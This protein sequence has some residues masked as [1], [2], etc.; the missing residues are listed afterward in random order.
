MPRNCPDWNSRLLLIDINQPNDLVGDCF[1]HDC[2]L[3][4]GE[5][6]S[7]SKLTVH[8]AVVLLR[9]LPMFNL[10]GDSK[11][12]HEF[13]NTFVVHYLGHPRMHAG[14]DVEAQMDAC[15]LKLLVVCKGSLSDI[16]PCP[17][18]SVLVD[19]EHVDIKGLQVLHLVSENCA[20]DGHPIDADAPV[21]RPDLDVSDKIESRIREQEAL[22]V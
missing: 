7:T 1:S 6:A 18:D 21:Q 12:I 13:V 10:P 3:S 22:Q 11:N 2:P 17:L 4:R 5:P 15:L 20:D 16:G 9:R 8:P 19:V 14:V